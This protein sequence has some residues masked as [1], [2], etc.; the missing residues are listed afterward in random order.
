MPLIEQTPERYLRNPRLEAAADGGALL[1][2]FAWSGDQECILRYDLA[3]DGSLRG[4]PVATDHGSAIM[5]WAPGKPLPVDDPGAEL[6]AEHQGWQAF[7]RHEGPR[8]K[9]VVSPPP[10]GEFVAWTAFGIAG[11]GRANPTS[12][13]EAL[14]LADRMAR[15][16]AGAV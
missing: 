12:F 5:A 16:R 14:K 9:V 4:E 1:H 6:E 8:S 7:V 11:Q 3:A 10:G 13:I 15:M 2:L